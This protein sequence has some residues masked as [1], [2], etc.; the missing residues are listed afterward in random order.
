MASVFAGF[1]VGYAVSLA[2]G[3][4][5]AV[6]IV[7]ANQ[8]SGFAQ[9]LAPPGT[10]VIALSVVLHVAAIVVFTGLGLVLGMALDGME[11]RRPQGGLGSPNLI[12]TLFVLALT[13]TFVIP[14]AALPAIRPY[15]LVG[16]LLF[17]ASFGWAM[18]WLATLG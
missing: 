6:L 15:T 16:S 1:V 8:R 2:I 18:P 9:R 14:S 3:P 7:R 17:V 10:S 4:L 5:A 11:T 13:A 12:Y